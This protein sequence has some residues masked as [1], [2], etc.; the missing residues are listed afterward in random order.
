MW[1]EPNGET[2]SKLGL[3]QSLPKATTFQEDDHRQN[4]INNKILTPQDSHSLFVTTKLSNQCTCPRPLK[5]LQ[6]PLYSSQIF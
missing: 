4:H 6:T 3:A 1:A 2:N 5:S